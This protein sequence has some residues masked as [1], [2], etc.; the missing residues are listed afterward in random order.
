MSKRQAKCS[1][2][3]FISQKIPTH[4]QVLCESNTKSSDRSFSHE[5]PASLPKDLFKSKISDFENTK[6]H[7]QYSRNS[8]NKSRAAAHE[9]IIKIRDSIKEIRFQ[10]VKVSSEIRRIR[11]KFESSSSFRDLSE[12]PK[13]DIVD[14]DVSPIQTN[15]EKDK[16]IYI[17]VNELKMQ[18][19]RLKK[20]LENDE[21]NVREQSRENYRLQYT[22]F[23]LQKKFEMIKENQ[24]KSA[25]NN[26]QCRLCSIF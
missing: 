18:L 14:F 7:S 10:S 11:E 2:L 21:E 19:A 25:I 8:Y 6:K 4:Q 16:N 1:S 3:H 17:K 5:D 23:S 9:N 12:E 15:T 24:T 22:I 20:R 13:K 26:S